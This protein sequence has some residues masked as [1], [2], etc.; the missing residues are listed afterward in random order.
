MSGIIY[1]SSINKVSFYVGNSS[2]NAKDSAT[3]ITTF[4]LV[5]GDIPYPQGPYDTHMGITDNGMICATCQ[6]NKRL[7]LGH[8]GHLDLKYPVQAPLFMSE[9]KKWLR[10]I[11]FHCGYPII[12]LDLVAHYP[13]DARL[14][15]ASKLARSGA[16]SCIVCRQP[17]PTISRDKEK[18]LMILAEE[19]SS[20]KGKTGFTVNV[21]RLYPHR[22]G[23]IFNKI[24]NETVVKLGKSIE[25][26]PRNFILSKI[27]IPPVT[28]RPDVRKVGTSRAS[29]G[30]LTTLIQNI[31]KENE[32]LPNSMP[33]EI[34]QKL[35]ANI[36]A[37][38]DIYYAFVKGGAPK[39]SILGGG[40]VAF[41][42]SKILRGKGGFFRKNL[43]GKR[44][45]LVA[46]TT[47]TGDPTLKINQ[48]AIPLKFAKTLQ[49]EEIVQEYNK[50]K[51]MINYLNGRDKYPGCT[52]IIKAN[53]NTEYSI[54]SGGYINS[55]IELEI[56]DKI[57]RD[58]ESGDYVLYNRQPSLLPSNI[59][60]ME[61]LVTMDPDIL[62][63]RMN[64]IVCPLNFCSKTTGCRIG[65]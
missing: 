50:K 22:I 48:L 60:A 34:D 21:S 56:G 24:T 46:R 18:P 5:K 64:V 58:L 1:P 13:K 3:P 65:N 33:A 57:Y 47:I 25:S 19:R 4:D 27:K 43:Q 31:I 49:V 51:L 29:G 26:H 32:K 11:C 6:N 45:R 30:D 8:D 41:S 17:H 63:F 7:C 35:E 37:L 10:L 59:S 38:N 2:L 16:K 36:Y 39:K 54:S 20:E 40:N 42:L 15:E 62:T 12:N 44:V 53:T 23:I 14:S 28:L 52:K 61:I 9:I 55:N